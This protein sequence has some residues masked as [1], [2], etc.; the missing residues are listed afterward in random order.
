MTESRTDEI[1]EIKN[2]IRA[3]ARQIRYISSL[4]DRKDFQEK[5]A[6]AIEQLEELLDAESNAIL[7]NFRND[8]SNLVGV[9]ETHGGRIAQVEESVRQ[10]GG[11]TLTTEKDLETVILGGRPRG[12]QVSQWLHEAFREVNDPNQ[13]QSFSC[14]IRDVWLHDTVGKYALTPIEY[15]VLA[16]TYFRSEVNKLAAYT[17]SITELLTARKTTEVSAIAR[18]L[19]SKGLLELKPP[20]GWKEL[21]RK[22]ELIFYLTPEAR[23]L[24]FTTS[25]SPS[26][27]GVNHGKLEERRFLLSLT[28]DK[29]LKAYFT[30]P[31][32][33]AGNRCDG[34]LLDRIERSGD[35]VWKWWDLTAVQYETS[36][37]IKG[38]DSTAAESEGQVFCNM[39]IPFVYGAKH[40]EVVCLEDDKEKLEEIKNE[41]PES[42]R[43]DARTNTDRIKIVSVTLQ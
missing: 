11:K 9:A 6:K 1:D 27:G 25:L 3:L 43:H 24:W 16:S 20:E 33:G 13:T 14:P 10:L 7:K 18:N 32:G 21:G 36:S 37:T 39:I 15:D 30:I 28:K 12:Q 4:D 8:L 5:V 2:E 29:P 26:A 23:K 40:L 19:Q 35:L 34:V 17:E 41:L 22:P 42:L 31:Q 38:N